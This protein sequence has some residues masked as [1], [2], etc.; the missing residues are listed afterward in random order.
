[1]PL[2][3]DNQALSNL[4]Y[5]LYG[6]ATTAASTSR[7]FLTQIRQLMNLQHATMI[8]RQPT[9]TDPGLIYTSGDEADIAIMDTEA[10]G[11]ASLYAQDPLVNLP[12]GELV[13]LSDQTPRTQLLKSDYYHLFLKPYNIDYV[14]GIDWLYEKNSRISVR[15]TREESQGDFTNDEKDFFRLLIPHF[16][17]SVTLGIQLRQLDSERQIYADSISKRAIGIITLDKNGNIL[18]S[19]TTAD[20]YLH[21]SDGLLQAK[22]QIKISNSALNDKLNKYITEALTEITNKQ[23]G[24]INALAVPR[25]SGKADYQI[26]IKPISVNSHDESDVTPYLTVLIQDP[27][28]NLEISVRTLMNLYQLT[29]SEATIAILLAEGH[30]TDE[31]A[32]ELDIKKNTV[33]A[34][35]RSMFVKM[36]VTQQSMLVSLVLTSLASTL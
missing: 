16:E 1:M 6:S 17:Q 36:G 8:V 33:R 5:A 11:Y 19:N 21:D 10:G 35:L 27:E 15:F 4:L 18:Q 7:Q 28:R 26:M 2:S 24:P 22:N 23:R 25:D 12:P 30:T 3:I 31:V 34:H 13:T 32:D 20:K 9:A 29:M 14:A